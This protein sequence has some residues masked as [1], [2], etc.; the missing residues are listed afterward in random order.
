MKHIVT[1]WI[2]SL[3]KTQHG[4]GSPCRTSCVPSQT[5]IHF[6]SKYTYTR[7]ACRISHSQP[8]RNAGTSGFAELPSI[9]KQKPHNKCSHSLSLSVLYESVYRTSVAVIT[10]P[11]PT[12][13]DRSSK[14]F[15]DDMILF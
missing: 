4:L 14:P 2:L 3:Q 9:I 10:P 13:A 5:N 7:N 11:L 8:R 1:I 15:I 12:A 6:V